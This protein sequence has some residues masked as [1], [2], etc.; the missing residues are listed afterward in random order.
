MVMPLLTLDRS[1]STPLFR[2]VEEALASAIASGALAAGDRLPSERDLADLLDVSR[3]T[4]MNAYRELE[5]RGLI[6]GRVGQGTFVCASA[7]DSGVPFAWQGKV[8]ASAQRTIDPTLRALVREPTPETISFAAGTP[9]FDQFP[10]DAFRSSLDRV[11][12]QHPGA[13]LGLGPTEGQPRLRAEIARRHRVRPEQVLVL[14]GSQQGLDLITRSLLDPSD[15]VVMDRPGYLGAIQTFRAAGA[16]VIGWDARRADPDELESLLQRYRPKLLYTNPTFQ[17][18]TGRT[19]P[20]DVRQEVLALAARYRLAVIEDEP[21]RDLAFRGTPPMSLR[22]LDDQGLVIHLGTFSKTLAAGLR[23]GWLIAP[24][25]VIDQLALMRQ[26]ADLFGAGLHQ[27]AVADLLARGLFDAHLRAL[28]AEHQRRHDAAIAALRQWL[29]AGTFTWAPA[30]GGLYLWL[31]AGQGIDTGLLEQQALLAGVAIVHGAHFYADGDGRHELRLCF[32]RCT[33]QA[34][35][36]GIERL[37]RV[38]RED[39]SIRTHGGVLRPLT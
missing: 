1:S 15:A 25:T 32:A 31:H 17:N 24:E 2:Q 22:E 9:A 27:L 37:A 4:A 34:I 23:L 12:E 16:R 38:V 6:R 21:Y 10:I 8:T 30:E 39:A 5:A 33:P 14:A 18:P 35:A 13:A 11:L 29:P 19:L 28:R 26:R 7:R 3:T 36:L 20:L